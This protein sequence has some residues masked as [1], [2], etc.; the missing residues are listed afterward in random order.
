MF[1][2]APS[3]KMWNPSNLGFSQHQEAWYCYTNDERIEEKFYSR[4]CSLR[5]SYCIQFPHRFGQS[6]CGTLFQNEKFFYVHS[7]TFILPQNI[8]KSQSIYFKIIIVLF[9][10]NFKFIR[11]DNFSIILFAQFSS[12]DKYACFPLNKISYLLLII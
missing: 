10:V 3:Y 9:F 1:S 7:V 2:E 5:H 6:I 12:Y 11:F 8:L 4:I